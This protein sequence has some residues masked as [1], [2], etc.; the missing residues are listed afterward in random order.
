MCEG[1]ICPYSYLTPIY[2]ER[3]RQLFNVDE[4][5]R[6]MAVTSHSCLRVSIAGGGQSIAAIA[7]L[8]MAGID[9]GLIYAAQN[10]PVG[11]AFA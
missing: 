1:M 2:M 5:Y 11:F 10:R 7:G 8:I 4:G 3:H 9:L 6:S